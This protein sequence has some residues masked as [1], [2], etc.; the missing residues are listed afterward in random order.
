MKF[1]EP[2]PKAHPLLFSWGSV[3]VLWLS[4]DPEVWVPS[5]AGPRVLHVTKEVATGAPGSAAST[6]T[7]SVLP[8]SRQTL[9][10][11]TV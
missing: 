3:R 4:Q 2:N 9:D 7:A 6:E 1:P 10:P 11:A 5:L 8:G